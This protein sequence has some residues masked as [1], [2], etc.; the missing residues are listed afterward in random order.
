MTHLEEYL[1]FCSQIET[2]YTEKIVHCEWA[3]EDYPSGYF[4]HP[5]ILMIKLLHEAND[6]YQPLIDKEESELFD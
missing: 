5:S 6:H 3:P 1:K 4:N 2:E